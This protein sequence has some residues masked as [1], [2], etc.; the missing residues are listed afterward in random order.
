MTAAHGLVEGVDLQA[1][2]AATTISAAG[3]RGRGRRRAVG[4]VTTGCPPPPA[5]TASAAR[6][7]RRVSE[8]GEHAVGPVHRG[9]PSG[10][11]ATG[12]MPLPCLPVDRHELLGPQAGPGSGGDHE[13]RL[14]AP[15]RGQRQPARRQPTGRRRSAA[16]F[17][18]TAARLKRRLP[19]LARAPAAPRPGSRRAAGTSR[20]EAPVTRSRV[21]AKLPPAETVCSANCE[22]PSGVGDRH[23]VGAVAEGEKVRTTIAA[24][25]CPRLPETRSRVRLSSSAS[26][27]A[28]TAPASVESS[29]YPQAPRLGAERAAQD[30]G[31][32][33][34]AAIPSNTTSVSPSRGR[35]RRSARALQLAAHALG[36]R[37]PAGRLATSGVPR[38]SP[39]RGVPAQALAHA[40]RPAARRAPAPQ[41]ATGRG[42]SHDSLRRLD[43]DRIVVGGLAC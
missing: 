26:T 25:S 1:Q 11:S 16:G 28:A 23:E 43:H 41:R 4:I 35:P 27:P 38:R 31:R 42:R 33:R 8:V 15:G 10:S 34:S 3:T 29:T 14:V 37:E 36:D 17:L 21:S 6:L 22:G 12:R 39:Q 13:R 9:S 30:L 24:R 5:R 7:R 20:T 40:A 2:P 19:R 32:Q 18:P